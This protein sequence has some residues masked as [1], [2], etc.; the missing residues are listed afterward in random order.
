M[1]AAWLVTLS[2]LVVGLIMS[3]QT[4]TPVALGRPI[5]VWPGAASLLVGGGL[6]AAACVAA[7][8][9]R[10]G[11]APIASAGGNHW[12]PHW[13]LFAATAPLLLGLGWIYHGVGA[14]LSREGADVLP[15]YV[16]A[17]SAVP[18]RPRALVLKAHRDGIT[19]YALVSGEERQLGDRRSAPA[20]RTGILGQSVSVLLSG[21]GGVQQV[22]DLAADG[23]GYLVVDAPVDASLEGRLDGV[24]GLLRVSSI[25]TGAVWRLI[26][27]GA[28]V[29]LVRPGG[30]ARARR[31]EPDARTTTVDTDLPTVGRPARWSWP[32]QPTR[33]RRRPPT[34]HRWSGTWPTAGR[35]PSRSRPVP[36]TS[37]SP[38][39]SNREGRLVAQAL[40][41]LVV[42]VLALPD[43]TPAW[44]GPGR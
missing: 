7:D 15:A 23:V 14:S 5:H 10:R 39:G 43:Q 32:R 19:T 27:P 18:S 33:L 13:P 8:G 22:V 24:P 30:G 26:A 31:R 9:S 21:H 40:V 3:A 34:A 36:T 41:L 42:V 2:G 1:V 29:Q 11:C 17:S 38:T 4:V 37:P 25:D 28:R 16:I 44:L 6:V 35:R 20:S 12:L